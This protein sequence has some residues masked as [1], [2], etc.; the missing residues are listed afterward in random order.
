MIRRIYLICSK[1]CA[2]AYNNAYFLLIVSMRIAIYI[3]ILFI[4]KWDANISTLKPN[5]RL[6]INHSK[7]SECFRKISDNPSVRIILYENMFNFKLYFYGF[8][9]IESGKKISQS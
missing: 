8:V 7:E 2:Q 1:N 9:S 5:K 3:K 6:Y 4:L